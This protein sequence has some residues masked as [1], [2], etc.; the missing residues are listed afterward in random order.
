VDKEGKIAEPYAAS[1]DHPD[2]LIDQLKKVL[3]Q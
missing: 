2:E 1:P 3:A